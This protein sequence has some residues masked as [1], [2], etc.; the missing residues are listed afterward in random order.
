MFYIQLKKE[1]SHISQ[2]NVVNN[3]CKLKSMTKWYGGKEY[4]IHRYI[5][6]EMKT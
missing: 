2:S 3:F 6:I 5:S 4:W 1:S